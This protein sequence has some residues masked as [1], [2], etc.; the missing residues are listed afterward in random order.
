MNILH[1]VP[2]DEYLSLL[3]DQAYLSSAYDKDGFIHCTKEPE[4]ML[5]IANRFYKGLTGDLLVLVIET[6]KVNAPIKWEPPAH[7]D[8]TPAQPGERLFP[9]IYGPLNRDAVVDVHNA[10]RDSD[11]NFLSV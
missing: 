10:E 7:P 1:L 9:H 3:P 2:A 8:G 5:Q 6:D 11:G 4:V